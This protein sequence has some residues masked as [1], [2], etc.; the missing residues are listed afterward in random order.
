MKKVLLLVIKV[1][2]KTV[3]LDH[4]LLHIFFK[5]GVCR[6]YPSCSEYSYE[7]ID[8]FGVWKGLRMVVGRI[9]RCHPWNKGGYD[10]VPKE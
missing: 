1:Y 4:G 9:R 2:Q 5:T 3:S 8:K 7:A 6:F 10:P